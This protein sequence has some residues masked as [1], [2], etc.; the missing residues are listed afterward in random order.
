MLFSGG[1][2]SSSC[3]ATMN[4]GGA[5]FAGASLVSSAP[6]I[7]TAKS[8][9]SAG[10]LATATFIA[11]IAPAENPIIP[12]RCGE[13]P[14]CAECARTKR[15]ACSASATAIALAPVVLAAK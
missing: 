1:T 3:A 14:N 2:W 12:S 10:S 7:E 15:T 6:Y 4:K 8:G 5:S 11:V 13:S 9:R